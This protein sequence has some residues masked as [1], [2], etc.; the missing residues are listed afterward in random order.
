MEELRKQL[1]AA[2]NEVISLQKQ[3]DRLTQQPPSAPPAAK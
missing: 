1:E 2:R 3:L